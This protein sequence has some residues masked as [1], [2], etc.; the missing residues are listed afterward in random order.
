MEPFLLLL[1]CVSVCVCALSHFSCVQIF[2]TSCTLARQAP[3]SMGFS[4]QEHWS[5]FLCPPPGDLPDPG[6][7]PMSLMSPALAFQLLLLE[8]ISSCNSVDFI[9]LILMKKGLKSRETT[10][11]DNLKFYIITSHFLKAIHFYSRI[12]DLQCWVGIAQG[13]SY[14]S[15]YIYIF[16]PRFYNFSFFWENIMTPGLSNSKE[17]LKFV[18]G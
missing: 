8:V 15:T 4:R 10:Y 11:N 5:G 7:E 6:I 1:F 13:F 16:F 3:L 12:V 14:T 2:V 9:V 17:H 18:S